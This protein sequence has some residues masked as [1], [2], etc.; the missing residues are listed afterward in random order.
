MNPPQL[1]NKASENQEMRTTAIKQKAA[2]TNKT[3][4]FLWFYFLDKTMA[5]QDRSGEEIP[6]LQ[7]SYE[8]NLSHGYYILWS[9]GLKQL[10][11]QHSGLEFATSGPCHTLHIL[12]N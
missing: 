12:R 9:M 3:K 10:E 6:I 1:E 8:Q 11:T 5:N 7:S 4:W 2:E